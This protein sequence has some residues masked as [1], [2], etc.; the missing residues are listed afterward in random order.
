[1]RISICLPCRRRRWVWKTIWRW[2]SFWPA[3]AGN[4]AW[5]L[6]NIL[7]ASRKEGIWTT[8]TTLYPTERILSILTYVVYRFPPDNNN[9]GEFFNVCSPR[10]RYPVTNWWRSAPRHST[11]W[12]YRVTIW[13]KCGASV[14]KPSWLKMRS[15]RTNYASLL[16]ELK[17]EALPWITV[18]FLPPTIESDLGPHEHLYINTW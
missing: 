12:S 11:R 8:Q 1:M 5:I 15:D 16:V 7:F 18:G 2:K 10:N 3:P 6:P 9:N 17:T 13:S 14:S 4:E